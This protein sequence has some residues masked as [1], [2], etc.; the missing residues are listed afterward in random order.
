MFWS[1]QVVAA[2]RREDAPLDAEG[3]VGQQAM[4]CSQAGDLVAAHTPRQQ[5]MA[6]ARS[7]D[8]QQ[9][10]S[11]LHLLRA[12]DH[13]LILCGI[14]GLAAFARLDLSCRILEEDELRYLAEVPKWGSYEANLSTGMK[15]YE[16]PVGRGPSALPFL[17]L[18]HDEASTNLCAMQFISGHLHL[19]TLHTR[20]P[21]HRFWNDIKNAVKDCDARSDVLEC[22]HILGL[23]HGPWLCNAWWAAVKAAVDNYFSTRDFS[24]PLWVALSARLGE[25]FGSDRF[26]EPGSEEEQRWLWQASHG[27][28]NV[29]PNWQPTSADPMVRGGRPMA[30]VRQRVPLALPVEPCCLEGDGCVEECLGHASVGGPPRGSASWRRPRPRAGSHLACGRAC[31]LP[32]LRSRFVNKGFGLAMPCT[33]AP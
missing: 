28:Q 11:S 1:C 9:Y 30:R 17:L 3:F 20:D 12:L 19:R 13:Q 8:A 25:E 31:R 21:V 24:D 16:V 32:L 22:V 26:A 27:Q 23:M 18:H 33:W 6:T 7:E 10:K 14:S 29:L 5:T 2:G 4:A 15:R